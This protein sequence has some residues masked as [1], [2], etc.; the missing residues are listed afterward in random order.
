M[1]QWKFS[2]AASSWRV[3]MHSLGASSPEETVVVNEEGDPCSV[4]AGGVIHRWL[5]QLYR[6]LDAHGSLS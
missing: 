1:I 3:L 2:E 4:D 6:A 5:A